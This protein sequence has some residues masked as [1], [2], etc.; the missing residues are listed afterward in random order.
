[1]ISTAHIA[2][3][4]LPEEHDFYCHSWPE[5]YPL[6]IL[7]RLTKI[8]IT[9]KN[10]QIQNDSDHILSYKPWLIN[11]V[12][13]NKNTKKRISVVMR[14]TDTYMDNQYDENDLILVCAE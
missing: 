14:L 10:Y 13:T 4:T 8:I 5:K 11:M 2:M 6:T 9:D 12:I 3:L 7:F 1:M